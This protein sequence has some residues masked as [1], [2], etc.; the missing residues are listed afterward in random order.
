MPQLV[1]I[2]IPAYN[3]ERWI[4]ETIS[5]AIGQTW[6]AT[7]IIVVDDGSTDRTLQVARQFQSKSVKVATQPNRGASTA[8][9]AALRLAQGEYIQWLDADDLLAPDKVARQMEQAGDG[10]GSRELLSSRFTTFCYRPYSS[11]FVPTSLWCDLS[12][13]DWFLRKFNDH[14]FMIPP[15]WLV[16][17]RL[18]EEVGPWDERLT[19]DDDGEYFSRLVAACDIVRFVPEAASFYRQANIHSLSKTYTY[20]ACRS[21]LLSK[22]LSIRYLLDL[23]DSDRTRAAAIEFLQWGMICFFPEK[24]ELLKELD[25][26]SAELGGSLSPPR[27]SRKYFLVRKIFGWK[28]AKNLALTLPQYKRRLFI[29]CDRF[30]HLL[31]NGTG[32]LSGKMTEAADAR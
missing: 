2:L 6:P 30:M 26:F 12:P 8:R 18:T 15:A 32:N 23:E 24:T 31:E 1:S 17:R 14:V 19:L 21:L 7:E 28:T 22:R 13:V 27:L 3:A 5:S 16:S 10:T 29:A 9:N 11:R 20:R 25:E 4:A